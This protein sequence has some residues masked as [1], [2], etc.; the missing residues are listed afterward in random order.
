MPAPVDLPVFPQADTRFGRMFTLRG[1]AVI[2]R[3]LRLYC[4]FAGDEVDSIITFLRPGDHVLDL[5][6]NIDV[7][8]LAF[9]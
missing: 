1:D 2:R 6:A 5:G 8:S 9:A 3:S 4:E 7:H